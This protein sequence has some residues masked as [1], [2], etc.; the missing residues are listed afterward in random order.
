GYQPCRLC[1]QQRY[2]HY[3][4]IGFMLTGIAGLRLFREPRVRK[5]SLLVVVALM[6]AGSALA[7]YHA[8]IEWA[9]WPGPKDCAIPGHFRMGD[10]KGILHQLDRIPPSCNSA[11]WRDPLLGLSFAGWNAVAST[12]WAVAGLIALFRPM[13]DVTR[14]L[15]EC[16]R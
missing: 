10:G 12:I 13:P 8:G 6:A 5:L 14:C 2:P 4:A 3:A 15:A 11:S 7:V 1:L 16:H 9:W